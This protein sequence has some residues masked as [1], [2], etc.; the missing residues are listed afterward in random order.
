MVSSDRPSQSLIIP[1]ALCS[2]LTVLPGCTPSQTREARAN[3]SPAREVTTAPAQV[4]DGE[5]SPPIVRV[6]AVETSLAAI[7]GVSN[8]AMEENRIDSSV[9]EQI[10]SVRVGSTSSRIIV[11]SYRPPG[12]GRFPWILLSHGTDFP[13]ETN[14]DVGRSRNL[15]LVHEWVRRGYAVVVPVR[16]GYGASGGREYS[17]RCVDCTVEDHITPGEGATMDILSAVEWSRSQADLDPKRWLLVGQSTGAFASIYAASKRPAG[18][19][20]VLAFAP[21]RRGRPATHPGEPLAADL[22]ADLFTKIGSRIEVPVLWFYA[23][24]D[25]F[26]GPRVQNLWFDSFRKA[27]GR[28]Q[29][30]VVDPPFPG[31][32]G[33]VVFGQA[34][35]VRVWTRAVSDFYRAQNI[36]LPF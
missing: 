12:G 34:G 4:R 31:R 17:D 29:L 21:G 26:F 7:H 13:L 30:T 2:L 33:H 18:L 22:M 35:G 25:E 23:R 27:G 1:F 20:A 9:R 11:T 8:A 28:G 6:P 10:Y 19:V 36:N 14:R 5:G 3:P 16:R 32:G 15:P 24:N